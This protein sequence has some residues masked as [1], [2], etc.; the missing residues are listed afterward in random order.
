MTVH[1]DDT[2]PGTI[3]VVA[4][5]GNRFTVELTPTP[6][7]TVQAAGV[8]LIGNSCCG[9]AMERDP[10][11]GRYRVTVD[12]DSRPAGSH[13]LTSLVARDTPGAAGPYGYYWTAPVKVTVSH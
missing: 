6:G 9:A 13:Y 7:V 8:A 12:L 11:T 2:V 3:A 1:L 4:T 10:A 5:T